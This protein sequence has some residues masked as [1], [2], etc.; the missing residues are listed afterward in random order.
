MRCR[1][2]PP[3]SP[4]FAQMLGQAQIKENTKAPSHWSLCGKSPVAG[5]FPVQMASHAENVS[6]WWRHHIC[7]FSSQKQYKAV[8][9]HNGYIGHDFLLETICY[10]D[11]HSHSHRY[12]HKH[13]I[14]YGIW[15]IL[16]TPYKLQTQSQ[17]V[18]KYQ[19]EKRM[20]TLMMMWKSHLPA[21]Y[22]LYVYVLVKSIH[23]NTNSR[24]NT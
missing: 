9:L 15:Y 6:I 7:M 2:K 3:V 4:V 23:T 8:E 12:E 19:S 21:L 22:K 11:S 20:S 14:D 16:G 17:R 10:S 1:L 24:G 5:E 18:T 13:S